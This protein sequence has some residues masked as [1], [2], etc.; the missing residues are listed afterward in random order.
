MNS[1]K[2]EI[3]LKPKVKKISKKTSVKSKKSPKSVVSANLKEGDSTLSISK[4]LKK[5]I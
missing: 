4:I 5:I 2:K 3:N 1:I